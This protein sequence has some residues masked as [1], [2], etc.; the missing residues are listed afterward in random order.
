MSLL[1]TRSCWMSLPGQALRAGRVERGGGAELLP[2]GGYR[3][4]AGF[5][6]ELSQ[7]LGAG[8]FAAQVAS[9][10]CLGETLQ[11]FEHAVGGAPR[12]CNRHAERQRGATLL[13]QTKLARSLFCVSQA[14]ER[15]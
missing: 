10:A 7:E 4:L 11:G 3:I 12:G 9:A 2:G 8:A 1:V 5:V 14:P 13:A 15:F 6:R